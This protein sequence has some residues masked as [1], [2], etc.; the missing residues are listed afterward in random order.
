MLH[1]AVGA[2]KESER[3]GSAFTP[4]SRSVHFLYRRRNKPI[5]VSATEPYHPRRHLC[6]AKIAA[7]DGKMRLRPTRTA[8]RDARSSLRRAKRVLGR[9]A[10]GSVTSKASASRKPAIGR[11]GDA[12]ACAVIGRNIVKKIRR[13]DHDLTLD[14]AELDRPHSENIVQVLV[15]RVA[16][17]I[18]ARARV[19]EPQDTAGGSIGGDFAGSHAVDRRPGGHRMVVGHEGSGVAGDVEPGVVVKLEARKVLG[20]KRRRPEHRLRDGIEHEAA[21]LLHAGLRPAK[22]VEAALEYLVLGDVARHGIA[23][24][25]VLAGEKERLELAV[26][27]LARREPRLAERHR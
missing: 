4:K 3:R 20:A 19:K 8:A 24:L 1:R 12:R 22:Q 25:V 11:D 15:R 16:V 2:C 7:R 13:E 14:E 26:Q 10:Y 18:G 9:T 21:Q 27:P 6:H 17:R 5:S 23:V